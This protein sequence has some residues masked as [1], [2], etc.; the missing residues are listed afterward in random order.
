M[1]KH[2]KTIPCKKLEWTKR[3]WLEP[4]KKANSTGYIYFN[5]E[6]DKRWYSDITLKI[7]DCQRS[8]SLDLSADSPKDRDR[9]VAKIKR[10][11]GYLQEFSEKMESIE[12]MEIETED[13]D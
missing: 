4:S 5:I 2:V 6:V 10:L 12:F 8:I 3:E 9:S 11:I 13:S 1:A 7:A